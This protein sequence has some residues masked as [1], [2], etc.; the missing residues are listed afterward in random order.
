MGPNTTIYQNSDSQNHERKKD[1]KR[2][3]VFI[4]L[5]IDTL[6]Y[7]TY[8][9]QVSNHTNQA[10]STQPHTHTLKIHSAATVKYTSTPSEQSSFKNCPMYSPYLQVIENE[11]C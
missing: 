6:I 3:L 8:F 11:T 10:T 7:I 9:P 2:K 5:F 1:H 4:G